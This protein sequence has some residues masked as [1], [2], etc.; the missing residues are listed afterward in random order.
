MFDI[1]LGYIDYVLVTALVATTIVLSLAG[2]PDPPP[3]GQPVPVVA[4]AR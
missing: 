1:G 4:E 2:T 3:Q